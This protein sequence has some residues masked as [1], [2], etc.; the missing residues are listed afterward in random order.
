M[1][2]TNSFLLI[3]QN[4]GR[5]TL[6]FL[7]ASFYP[8]CTTEHS[9]R[10][11]ITKYFFLWP[12]ADIVTYRFGLSFLMMHS[13]QHIYDGHVHIFKQAGT[14]GHFGV[15]RNRKTSLMEITFFNKVI[16]PILIAKQASVQHGT[17]KQS[18]LIQSGQR[19]LLKKL[20]PQSLIPTTKKK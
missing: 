17:R 11:T 15:E 7:T 13:S 4:I 19:K 14:V 3:L 20:S 8:A 6:T 12:N 9:E 2:A 10:A 18:K 1:Q 5:T 16:L